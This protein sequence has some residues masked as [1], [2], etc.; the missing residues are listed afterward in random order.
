MQTIIQAVTVP[1][2]MQGGMQL[3]LPMPNG[4]IF[5]VLIPVGLKPGQ[6]F[7]MKAPMQAMKVS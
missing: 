3:Q 6:S 2:G 1:H 5:Q 4:Q 7:L